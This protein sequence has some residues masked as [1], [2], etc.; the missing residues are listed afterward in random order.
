[1]VKNQITE[2]MAKDSVLRKNQ[3]GF[4]KLCAAPF[5]WWVFMEGPPETSACTSLFSMSI[6]ML[7]NYVNGKI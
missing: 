4:V 1:M 7:E 3:H 2:H 6:K 5:A